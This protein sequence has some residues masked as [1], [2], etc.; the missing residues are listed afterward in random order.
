MKHD[1]G[2]KL[3]QEALEE[4]RKIIV[5]MRKR[6]KTLRE[7]EE[8][9]QLSRTTISKTLKNY[10]EQGSKAY[11]GKKR[12]RRM[13]ALRHLSPDKEKSIRRK[14]I[15][16]YPE[17]LKLDFALWTRD[18]VRQLILQETGI[19]MPIRTV[20]EYLKRWG[21]TPQKPAKF[22]YE[23][24]DE[25][26]KFWLEQA[27]PA[28]RERAKHEKAEIYWS[29]ETGMK[30]GDVRGRG[31]S[32]K[33]VT[34]IVNA[35]AKYESLSM[36]SAITNRGRIHWMIVDGTVNKERFIEFLE[37]LCKSTKRKVFLVLDN[38][39]VHHSQVVREWLEGK[40]KKIELFFLPA[41][42]PDLNPDE[43]VNA[44]MKQ[45]V[46][47]KTPSRNKGHLQ[48][49]IES[50]MEMLERNPKRIQGYFEDPTIKY[51]AA[52]Y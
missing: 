50:H 24:K 49:K 26:V 3:S 12:G 35:T 21:F 32:P 33:G 28:I 44:D 14:I 43:H 34:P 27:Y 52:S 1:D 4:R 16:R 9:V 6:G 37:R 31:Y 25:Q 19:A 48:R 11:A 2:R 47:S 38:L 30:A 20:G 40:E 29:D 22:A 15:D 8:T 17:Q 7:I 23:R 18:A 13:G 51:A 41:Y 10:R 36:I 46:G 39:R 5:R 45:G 42:S